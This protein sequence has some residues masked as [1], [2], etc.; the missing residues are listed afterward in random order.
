MSLL[1]ISAVTIRL[2]GRTLLDAADLDGRSRPPHR[3][4]RPQRR[5]QIHPAARHRRR[6]PARRRRHPPGRARPPRPP[7]RRRRRPAR[8]PCSTPCCKATPNAWP[9]WP[10]PRHADPHRLAEIHD[11]LHRHRRRLRPGPRRRHPR[12]PRLRRSRPGAPGAGILRRLAHARRPGHRAVRQPRSAAARRAD[13][14]PR[15]RS[16]AVAGDLA[17]A[18]PRRRAGRLARPRPA[19]PRACKPSPIST[20]ARSRSPPAASTNSSAS[21]PS[22]RMQQSR[23]A[24]RIAAE[25]AHIQAFIDRFRYKASK[26]RQA[27]ARH[28]GAGPTAADRNGDRGRADPLRL[29]R[30]GAHRP[31]DPGAGPRRRRL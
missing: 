15:P 12:R 23:A 28:Q 4:G 17:G 18:L 14:P 7:S 3:P 2:G 25:R 11:R 9:C 1:T 8:R 21:A 10:K 26:A 30:T 13:Q 29:S 24:E 27:Q 20:A 22:A 6:P 16:D 19:R 31:A 5:R